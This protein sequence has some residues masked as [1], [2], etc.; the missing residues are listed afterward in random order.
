MLRRAMHLGHVSNSIERDLDVGRIRRRHRGATLLAGALSRAKCAARAAGEWIALAE[1]VED[2]APH[3]SRGI[4][5]ERSAAVAP[6]SAG[7][8]H[9]ADKAPGDEVL[10]IGAAAPRIDG[11][12][13]DRS[14][15]LKVRDDAVISDSKSRIGHGTP[16]LRRGP[17]AVARS[18]SIAD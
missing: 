3:P 18:V 16:P 6:I 10:T 9:Q 15:E 5:A 1:R 13:G 8:L 12:G 17:Y 11:P 2:L 7:R 4:C 14:R